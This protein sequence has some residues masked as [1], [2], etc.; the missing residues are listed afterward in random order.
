[1]LMTCTIDL[2]DAVGLD[3]ITAVVEAGLRDADV[4]IAYYNDP[5]L[6]AVYYDTEDTIAQVWRTPS[7]ERRTS[8]HLRCTATQ[9]RIVQLHVLAALGDDTLAAKKTRNAPHLTF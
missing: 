2:T 4:S 5:D 6:E 9:R 3:Q 7:G 1:M 8:F